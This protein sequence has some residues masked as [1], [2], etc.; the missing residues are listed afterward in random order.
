MNIR[1]QLN[2]ELAAVEAEWVDAAST[3]PP[4][5]GRLKLSETLA[6]SSRRNVLIERRRDLRRRLA[7]LDDEDAATRRQQARD[8]AKAN[9]EDASFWF[10]RFFTTLSIANAAAFA[11]LASGL[12]QA[13]E[14][15]NIA[16]LVAPAMIQFAW[17]MLTAGS[18]PLLLWL[19]FGTDDWLSDNY[20]QGKWVR[21]ARW[22]VKFASQGAMAFAAVL[23]VTFFALGLF[24]ALGSIQGIIKH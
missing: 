18:V 16:P 15:K 7:A 5:K 2:Q 23:S 20:E 19:R 21:G 4:A 9:A 3:P 22:T 17:G 24:T 12:L 10:R 11:A 1:E 8:L 6:Q 13:D 14:P